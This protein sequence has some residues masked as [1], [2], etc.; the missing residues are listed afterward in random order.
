[1]SLPLQLGLPA[2]N[3]YLF[4]EKK[5]LFN[6]GVKYVNIL[7]KSSSSLMYRQNKLERFSPGKCFQPCPKFPGSHAYRLTQCKVLPFLD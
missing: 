7:Q 6:I 2:L 3:V 5:I 4:E 1:V